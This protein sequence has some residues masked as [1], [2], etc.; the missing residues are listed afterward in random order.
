MSPSTLTLNPLGGLIPTE[1]SLLAA[2]P[3]QLRVDWGVEDVA[4]NPVQPTEAIFCSR[5]AETSPSLDRSLQ[6]TVMVLP[7]FVELVRDPT[8]TPAKTRYVTATVTLAVNVSTDPQQ[9]RLV[10][11]KVPLLRHPITV[12]AIPVPTV[13]IF[14]ASH[15]LGVVAGS[16][17][18]EL[19]SGDQFA[20]I[21]VPQNSPIG[22][23]TALRTVFDKLL[24]ITGT[25]NQIVA[26]ATPVIG[27]VLPA[28]S[29]LGVGLKDVDGLIRALD[30]HKVSGGRVGVAF[31]S[32]DRIPNLNE[33]DTILDAEH[34]GPIAINDVEAED[35]ISS[36]VFLAPPGRQL[37]C[38]RHQD[39]KGAH[40]TVTTGGA[41]LAIVRELVNV[42]PQHVLPTNLL[43]KPDVDQD[44]NVALNNRLSAIAFL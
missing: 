24:E 15:T 20:L 30:V 32:A 4:G 25:L 22:G 44:G 11:A 23:I 1:A 2:L 9:P 33:I 13:A 12:P 40:V 42:P 43:V 18:A 14:F 36:F 10:E 26:L 8:E 19:Q 37:R 16:D 5:S 7:D 17:P 35:T 28:L 27:S 29:E 31:I 41:C 21:V 6:T 38:F 39:Y 3:V 34:W